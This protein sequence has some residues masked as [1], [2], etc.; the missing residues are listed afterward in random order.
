MTAT[1][2]SLLAE[3]TTLPVGQAAAD[4]ADPML[5][6]SNVDTGRLSALPGDLKIS[7]DVDGVLA[8]FLDAFLQRAEV[9]GLGRHFPSHWTQ[10]RQW[11]FGG[12]FFK[13]VW[14][15]V[16][17][18]Y[19]FW[20]RAV[21]RHEDAYLGTNEDPIVPIAAYITARPVP[22]K[23]TQAWLKRFD[24]PQAPVIT[25]GPGQSKLETCQRLGIDL[26]IDDKVSTW[27]ELN[28][29]GVP[30][31]LRTRPHNDRVEAGDMRLDYLW[32]LPEKIAELAGGS[33]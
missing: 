15:D 20:F 27:E 6:L 16:E 10:V 28:A 21:T 13:H 29:N 14:K 32:Q 33:E 19:S 12:E 9:I 3:T 26:M 18:D 11:G 22:S 24:F 30:C 1:A 2:A 7:F 25:V 5:D 23:V 4:E 8:N 17:K 31:L